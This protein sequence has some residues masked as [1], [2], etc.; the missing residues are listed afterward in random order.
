MGFE[1]LQE[2]AKF[3]QEGGALIIEGSTAAL[4]AEYELE[5]A[6]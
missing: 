4:M 2:L 5:Q 6:A 1:G 3:V